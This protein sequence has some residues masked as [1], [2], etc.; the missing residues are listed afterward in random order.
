MLQTSNTPAIKPRKVPTEALFID[1]E[2]P[3]QFIFKT[4]DMMRI[5]PCNLG[6]PEPYGTKGV[7]DMPDCNLAHCMIAKGFDL[8]GSVRYLLDTFTLQNRMNQEKNLS[9]CTLILNRN[10]NFNKGI[11]KILKMIVM[12]NHPAETIS[13][14]IIERF[15][16]GTLTY[17]NLN[18]LFLF[19]SRVAKINTPKA[20]PLNT[21]MKDLFS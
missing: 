18:S 13:A 10:A 21:I 7:L 11:N 14:F 17:K 6:A 19:L 1:W 15:P 16:V 12:L 3:K 5:G 8:N 20:E 2:S 9:P 4:F